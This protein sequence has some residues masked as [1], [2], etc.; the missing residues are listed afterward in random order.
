MSRKRDLSS[1]ISHDARIA[2]LSESKNGHLAIVLYMMAIP[3][4]DDWGRLPGNPREFK[5]LICPGFDTPK[6]QIDAAMSEIARLGLWD[7]YEVDGKSYVAFP[8]EAWFKRQSYINIGKRTNDKGSNY[9]ANQQ[10]LEYSAAQSAEKGA[11]RGQNGKERQ[12]TAENGITPSPSPTPSSPNGE[13]M[14]T[15][16]KP[17]MGACASEEVNSEGA[18]T[19]P[20]AERPSA[21]SEPLETAEP[22]KAA[23]QPRH[24]DLTGFGRFYGAYPKKKD[25]KL[26]QDAWDRLKPDTD[27]QAVILAHVEASKLTEDWQRDGGQFIP[28]PVRYLKNRRWEDELAPVST[29]APEPLTRKVYDVATGTAKVISSDQFR[30]SDNRTGEMRIGAAR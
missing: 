23:R 27:L 2:E 16:A 6:Q 15:T 14:P 22:P 3:Q 11:P 12:G 4:A 18:E 5:M 20:D 29:P 19:E 9:P 10:F 17:P 25:P 7:R 8:P 1:D 26:A 24:H 30:G 21:E 28:Y 13:Y